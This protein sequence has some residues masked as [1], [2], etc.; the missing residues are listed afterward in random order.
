MK[1]DEQTQEPHSGWL[2]Y[3]RQ[4]LAIRRDEVAPRIAGIR[5]T[6]C[7]FE[8][9]GTT[10]LRARFGLSGGGALVLDA[11]LGD[12]PEPK[13]GTAPT[14]RVIFATHPD[15]SR[16]AVERSRWTLV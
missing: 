6:D 15:D 11:N 1:W 13:L 12:A 7:S 4:L 2:A 16:R 5:G 14:G 3:Y 10:G 9:I 8:R